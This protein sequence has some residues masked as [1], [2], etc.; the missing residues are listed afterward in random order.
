MMIDSTI[1][2]IGRSIKKREKSIIKTPLIAPLPR[3]GKRPSLRAMT[4]WQT[5]SESPAR[6]DKKFVEGQGRSPYRQCQAQTARYANRSRG[7]Q[8]GQLSAVLCC[9]HQARR[10]IC[11]PDRLGPPY[12]RS[13][14]LAVLHCFR[15]ER[16]RKAP[17]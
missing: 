13:A 5:P 17:V 2:K 12:R 9:P 4:P 14:T 8:A 6:R 15:A 16:G 1:A 3:S 11:G 10:R 7:D